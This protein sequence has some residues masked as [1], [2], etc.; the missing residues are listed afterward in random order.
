MNVKYLNTPR[1]SPE[2]LYDICLQVL[3]QF[4]DDLITGPLALR[5][6]ED[7]SIKLDRLNLTD[8]ELGAFRSELEQNDPSRNIVNPVT[9]LLC[10]SFQLRDVTLR[11]IWKGL[12]I[13]PNDSDKG[14]K[15]CV[16]HNQV[17]AGLLMISLSLSSKPATKL[18]PLRL[19]HVHPA[20]VLP[21]VKKKVSDPMASE[22]SALMLTY[23]G[24]TTCHSILSLIDRQ[25]E[26]QMDL[27]DFQ[28]I[29]L[30]WVHHNTN[31]AIAPGMTTLTEIAYPQHLL[32]VLDLV[33][34]MCFKLLYHALRITVV[35]AR[36][37]EMQQAAPDAEAPA[38]EIT[39]T[40]GRKFY[41]PYRQETDSILRTKV[42]A[43]LK[44]LNHVKALELS[45]S[46]EET[47]ERQEL[48]R[49]IRV[50]VDGS[51]FAS[52]NGRVDIIFHDGM[53]RVDDPS[54]DEHIL[55]VLYRHPQCLS[56]QKVVSQYEYCTIQKC[57]QS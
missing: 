55:C 53:T 24:I 11:A 21:V 39:V 27:V 43:L 18:Q 20:F 30:S 19:Y 33:N 6:P 5:L 13:E 35:S 28:E 47:K 3:I 7:S 56:L 42:T 34:V 8:E 23:A 57:I 16:I 14:I 45:E 37:E 12:H 48:A 38:P 49:K 54:S 29:L 41:A 36:A 51:H 52:Y 46:D 50:H 22:T 2:I 25:Y 17:V 4:V 31:M 32:S 15:T 1:L 9:A 44:E 26:E 10:T 40:D